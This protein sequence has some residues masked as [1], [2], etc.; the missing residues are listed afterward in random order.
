MPIYSKDNRWTGDNGPAPAIL[1]IG[2]SWFWYPDNNILQ[3]LLVHPKFNGVYSGIQL[4]GLNGAH[5]ADYVGKGQYAADFATELKQSWAA[6]YSAFFISGGGND[7]VSSPDAVTGPNHLGLKADCTG[8]TVPQDCFDSERL[9]D[10]LKIISGALGTMIHDILWVVQQDFASGERINDVDIFVHGY[11]YPVPDGRGYGRGAL[12]LAGPWLANHMNDAFVLNDLAFRSAICALLIDNLNTT[13]ATFD[14][15]GEGRVHYIDSRNTLS[16]VLAGNRY[17][18]DWA[19]ELHPTRS[20]FDKIVDQ[21]WIS[22]L[23]KCGY[24]K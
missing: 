12:E 15:Q 17:Q 11:D 19:N 2:D 24:A 6:N 9:S 5:M 14:G 22:A 3:S 21:K 7:A 1:A 18:Q 13:L 20:G 4:L 16:A 23:S 10:L 8:I